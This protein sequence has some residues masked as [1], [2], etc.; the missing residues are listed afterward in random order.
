MR[1]KPLSTQL[2]PLLVS[3]AAGPCSGSLKLLSTQFTAENFLVQKF[4]PSGALQLPKLPA[5]S[6]PP[7]CHS[8][9]NRLFLAMLGQLLL[10]K[11]SFGFVFRFSTMATTFYA[12]GKV[13]WRDVQTCRAGINDETQRK[14]AKLVENAKKCQK[15]EFSRSL[16]PVIKIYPETK[17][18]EL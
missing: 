9:C 10:R 15:S 18:V 14:L 17:N 7:P 1:G 2:P 12:A 11:C 6:A 5:T 3:V 4:A 13:F 16:K 8:H